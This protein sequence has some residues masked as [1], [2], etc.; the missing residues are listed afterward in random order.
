MPTPTTVPSS[1]P[2][3]GVETASGVTVVKVEVAVASSSSAFVAE[4]VRV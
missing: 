1:G 4:A 3:D 2:I